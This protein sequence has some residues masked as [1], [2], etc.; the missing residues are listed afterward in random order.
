MK[1][2]VLLIIGFTLSFAACGSKEEALPEQTAAPAAT[3]TPVP[4]A[5]SFYFD[6]IIKHM[7]AHADQLDQINIALAD[8][9]LDA[10][11]LPARWLWR[12]DTISGVPDDLQPYLIGMREAARAVEN[13]ADLETARAASKR[14]VKQCQG[15]HTATG[16]IGTGIGQEDD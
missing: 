8:G 5:E 6:G 13:A 4:G 12:H 1:F 14:I 2:Y 11:K 15:C 9:D 3:E 10:S 7:H 16:V